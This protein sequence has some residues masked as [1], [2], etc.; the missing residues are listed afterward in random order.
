MSVF[1]AFFFA[2]LV[3]TKCASLGGS[4]PSDCDVAVT[5]QWSDKIGPMSIID[6][7]DIRGI[8]CLMRK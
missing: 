3:Q 4:G 2:P 5:S 8:I 6:T 1:N 7:F